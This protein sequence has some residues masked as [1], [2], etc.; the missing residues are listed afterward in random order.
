VT[1]TVAITAPANSTTIHN[2]VD[3]RALI[4][5]IGL[6]PA[7]QVFAHLHQLRPVHT[8]SQ[9][10]SFQIT[11]RWQY[12]TPFQ[13]RYVDTIKTYSARQLLLR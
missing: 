13:L 3:T 2:A 1:S 6:V 10:Q 11:D 8:Q 9:R 5:L 4:G 12:L 7:H